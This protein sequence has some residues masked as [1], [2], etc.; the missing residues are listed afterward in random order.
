MRIIFLYI[1]QV[2][3]DLY[4]TWV[5]HLWKFPK[6]S[7]SSIPHWK[8]FQFSY[9]T[10][11]IFHRS[12]ETKT[13][14]STQTQTQTKQTANYLRCQFQTSQATDKYIVIKNVGILTSGRYLCEVMLENPLYSRQSE[15]K[16]LLVIGESVSWWSLW[17]SVPW[18]MQRIRH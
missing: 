6:Y 1:F 11:K 18:I 9:Y 3:F 4:R 15:S 14:N 12:F 17:L 7:E 10:S 16:S 13:P 8:R 5:N 2:V